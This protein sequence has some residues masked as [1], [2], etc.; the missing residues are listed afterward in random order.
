MSLIALCC[1]F[2]LFFRLTSDLVT[3][4]DQKYDMIETESRYEAFDFYKLG[5]RFAIQKIDPRRGRIETTT[6]S[7]SVDG[8]E[9]EKEIPMVDCY[10]FFGK[11]D[12]ED[13]QH[14]RHD[15]HSH[16]VLGA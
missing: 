5:Y 3:K 7:W 8:R 12:Y 11:Q 6:K 13:S 10:K 16:R 15:G 1:V 14:T 4:A 2:I 9:S